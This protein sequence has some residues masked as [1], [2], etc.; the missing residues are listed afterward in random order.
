MTAL[1]PFMKGLRNMNNLQ[2]V[3]F[4]NQRII[5]TKVLAE[6]FGTNEQ[7]ISRNFLRNQERFIEGK[8]YFR[9]EGD[10]L[11]EFKG[12]VLKDDTLKFASNL[13]L[14]TDK[15]VARHAKMLETD[16]A[17]EIYEELEDTYFKVQALKENNQLISANKEIQEL[18]ST[19]EDFKKVTEEVWKDIK[20][21]E[22][23][24]QVSN[25]G[26]VRSLNYNRTNEIKVIKETIDI[27][28]YAYVDLS[29]RGEKKRYKVHRLVADTFI[30]KID[31]KDNIDHINT[32]RT[33]NRVENLR[34]CTHKENMNNKITKINLSNSLKGRTFNKKWLENMSKAQRGAKH[35]NY[36]KHLS[37]TT[38]IKIGIGNKGK[39]VS[40]ETKE[41]LREYKGE[42]HSNIKGVICL[43]TNEEFVY[44]RQA[45]EKYGI[46]ASHIS[47]CCK[48]NGKR[49]SAG[50][51]PI[52][53]E[54]MLW[55]YT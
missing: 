47:D 10:E 46:N 3:E 28:G 17:W 51:H 43:T 48:K 39:I 7:N 26:R 36:G 30:S 53:G 35:H 27:N 25:L 34:W 5:T 19:L 49:K 11:K 50:K 42:K 15:G 2:P 52:T 8:H 38:K 31:S 33:D 13:Y 21:Y 20:C 6:Q 12:Y 4:K 45:T 41:K 14:W 29:K 54:K 9:L 37:E 22:G 32:I 1:S 40:E 16:E 24:Y 44:I 55:E 18:K 23:L